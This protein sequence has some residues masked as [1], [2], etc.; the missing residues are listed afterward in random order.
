MLNR[1]KKLVYKKEKDYKNSNY[2][3][4]VTIFFVFKYTTKKIF[5]ISDINNPYKPMCNKLNINKHIILNIVVII[6]TFIVYLA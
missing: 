1:L 5:I 6:V 3:K 4:I 2:F